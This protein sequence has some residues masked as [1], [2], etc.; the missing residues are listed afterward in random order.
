MFL[1]P[2][3]INPFMNKIPKIIPPRRITR[4]TKNPRTQ[5]QP[6]KQKRPAQKTTKGPKQRRPRHGP[7]NV[8][9]RTFEEASTG[10]CRAPDAQTPRPHTPKA[11]PCVPHQRERH[12]GGF[13]E[14]PTP[15]EE[16]AGDGVEPKRPRRTSPTPWRHREG[17]RRRTHRPTPGPPGTTTPTPHRERPT[18]N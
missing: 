7:K 10:P 13:T 2:H 8:S 15:V 12:P 9:R 11:R 18:T 14:T 3:F 4:P 1:T 16:N 17:E 5:F 6:E